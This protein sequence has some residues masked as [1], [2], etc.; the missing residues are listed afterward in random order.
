MTNT[1]NLFIEE[2]KDNR[3]SYNNLFINTKD[4]VFDII[5]L[6]SDD[7]VDF[8]SDL[9]FFSSLTEKDLEKL[10]TILKRKYPSFSITS[11]TTLKSVI[12]K[13]IKADL[14][15]YFFKNIESILE[16]SKFTFDSSEIYSALNY[17]KED[18]AKLILNII[19]NG[20]F[21]YSKEKEKQYTLIQSQTYLDKLNFTLIIQGEKTGDEYKLID[22][23]PNLTSCNN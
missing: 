6:T 18:Y 1:N 4:E 23:I 10:N 5:K 15:K 7:N 19:V 8:S 3:S 16:Q 17:T 14:K 13:V 20:R 12:E 22:V 2:R 21:I 11:G 9:D